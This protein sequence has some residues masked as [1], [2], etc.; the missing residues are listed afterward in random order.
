MA[1]PSPQL[2]LLAISTDDT[3]ASKPLF[4]VQEED[5]WRKLDP[6]E[7]LDE[8]GDKESFENNA[9]PTPQQVET[10]IDITLKEILGVEPFVPETRTSLEDMGKV[11]FRALLPRKLRNRIRDASTPL[12][13]DVDWPTKLPILRVYAHPTMEWIPWE[14]MHDDQDFLGLRYQ[15]A[16]LP[17]LMA[18][19]TACQQQMTVPVT[20]AG[21][22]LGAGLLDRTDADFVKW[23]DTF[24]FLAGKLSKETRYPDDSAGRGYPLLSDVSSALKAHEGIIHVTC[25]GVLVGQKGRNFAWNL[26]D[27]VVGP[28]QIVYQI[29]SKNLTWLQEGAAIPPNAPRPLVFGNA[30]GGAGQGRGVLGQGFGRQLIRGVRRG[31]LCGRIREGHHLQGRGVCASFLSQSAERKSGRKRALDNRAGPVEN[32]V[33]LSARPAIWIP[34]GSS[35]VFGGYRIH[36][37]TAHYPSPRR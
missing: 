7:P 1:T 35:T 33:R 4:L 18:Q 19:N 29:K 16:R 5:L 10:F 15:I 24:S 17:I 2:S 36:A 31:G 34:H 28:E 22:F 6:P 12:S 20:T 37:F 14:L 27:T 11:I 9:T 8:Q 26:K 23:E 13:S 21:S 25:H 32:Q 30:C 3:E